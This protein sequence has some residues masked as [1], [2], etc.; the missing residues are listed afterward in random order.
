MRHLGNVRNHNLAGD[1]LSHG[2]G[3][4]GSKIP[5]FLRLQQIPKHNGN[6]L[7]VGHF[8]SHRRFSGDG[9]LDTNVRSRQIQLYVIR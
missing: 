8:D 6:A 7:F 5:E 3:Y 2:K 1:I 4:L 9:R